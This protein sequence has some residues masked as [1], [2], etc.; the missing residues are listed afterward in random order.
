MGIL[1][2][3]YLR[4]LSVIA[5]TADLSPKNQVPQVT[6][7][8][9]QGPGVLIYISDPEKT[10]SDIEKEVAVFKAEADKSNSLAVMHCHCSAV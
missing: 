8:K 5:L 3:T 7:Q 4:T 9:D 2:V 6:W 1:G 10:N